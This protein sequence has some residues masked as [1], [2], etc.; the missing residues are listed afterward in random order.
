METGKT[1]SEIDD[2]PA[3]EQ[4]QKAAREQEL[5]QVDERE[6]EICACAEFI[7]I[8]NEVKKHGGT[9]E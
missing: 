2:R 7:N 1:V 9:I 3:E 8:G 5:R 4:Q 6:L